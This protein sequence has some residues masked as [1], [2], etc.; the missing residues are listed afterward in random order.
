MENDVWSDPAVFKL[1]R[2]DFILLQLY[3]DD[4]TELLPEE[5]FISA[6]SGK[7]IRN[8]GAKWS[9][10]EADRFGANSQPFYVMLDSEGNML[11]DKNGVEIK[12]SAANKNINSYKGF[13]DSGI[14]AF[15][16]K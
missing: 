5:Q 15:H 7:K 10:L 12:P 6:Y 11:K 13:L 9:D 3:V 4:K 16:N 14:R 2:D 8:L 1:L